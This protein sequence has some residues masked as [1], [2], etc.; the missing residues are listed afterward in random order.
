MTLGRVARRE[1]GCRRVARAARE[2]RDPCRLPKPIALRD[3]IRQVCDVRPAAILL[4]LTERRLPASGLELLATAVVLLDGDLDM[5]Y[6]NPAAENLFE[7][8]K[9]Q[10]VDHP[11]KSVFGDAAA[12]FQAIDKALANGAS[13]TEQ[14]LEVGIGGK[15]RL[16]LSCT[17]SDRR[18]S[19]RDPAAGIPP[20][21]SAAEDRA[22]G[23]PA[24]TAAGESRPDPQPGARDQE[25]ARRHPRRGA[26]ARARARAPA[27]ASNTR[28]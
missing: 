13:Y 10:L 23:A 4:P 15:P 11:A 26:T 28:R 24:R 3:A 16:H 5:R 17:V 1:V 7:L 20:H 9:R 21:R 19:G 12:L 25:S 22:R 18:C 8:S 14:E 6:A 27:A 2:T